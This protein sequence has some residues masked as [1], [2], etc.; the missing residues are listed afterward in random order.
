MREIDLGSSLLLGVGYVDGDRLLCCAQGVHDPPIPLGPPRYVNILGLH[1]PPAPQLSGVPGR[2]RVV[3]VREGTAVV[4]A[5]ELITD[6]YPDMRNIAVGVTASTG[7]PIAGLGEFSPRWR[8]RLGQ[9]TSIS[10]LDGPHVVSLQRSARFDLVTYFAVLVGYA[11]Q[12]ANALLA[13]CYRW[14]YW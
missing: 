14:P 5:P 2:T 1:I 10:I 11:R 9:A 8:Q 7:V 3:G 6:L 12:P 13:S 4:L